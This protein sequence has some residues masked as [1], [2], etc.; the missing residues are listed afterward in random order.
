[1][2]TSTGV[3]ASYASEVQATAAWTITALLA[4]D[5]ARLATFGLTR[6]EL[7]DV[8]TRA[9]EAAEIW[10]SVMATPAA[11]TV[12]AFAAVH[13]PQ[14]AAAG[15]VQADIDRVFLFRD[16]KN[17]LESRLKTERRA[18]PGRAPND[19]PE[20]VRTC[21][22]GRAAARRVIQGW[23]DERGDATTSPR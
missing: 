4:L 16:L 3:R 2:Q 6:A 21:Y 22:A 20:D 18:A 12:A 23:Q 9:L 15:L 11:T 13:G 14:I 1:M 19:G 5:D 10:T 8:N 17:D 7:R